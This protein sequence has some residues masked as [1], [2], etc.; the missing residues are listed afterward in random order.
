ML[1]AD[2]N[3]DLRRYLTRLLSPYWTVETAGDGLR[4][5]GDDPRA[6]PDLVVT[7]VMMPRLDGFG[8]LAGAT[9]LAGDQELP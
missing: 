9:E 7:D 2:D 5:A 3:P 6:P 1:I 8:L 4:G